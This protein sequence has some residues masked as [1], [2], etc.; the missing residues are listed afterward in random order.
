MNRIASARKDVECTFGIIK[1]RF[2]VLKTP[3]LDAELSDV[4]DVFT[5]CAIFHNMLLDHDSADFEDNGML[6]SATAAR[7]GVSATTDHSGVA[8]PPAGYWLGSH[9]EATHVKLR[10]QLSDHLYYSNFAASS[11]AAPRSNVPATPDT[12]QRPH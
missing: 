6:D 2:R 7:S 11:P 4:D 10:T 8:G 3:M 12:V 9:P 5:A 1:S